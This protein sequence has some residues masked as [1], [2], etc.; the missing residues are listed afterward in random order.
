MSGAELRCAFVS[1]LAEADAL[2]HFDVPAAT[3]AFDQDEP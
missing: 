3:S 1:L 2:R